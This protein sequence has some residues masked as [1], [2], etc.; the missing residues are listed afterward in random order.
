MT[1]I[2]QEGHDILEPLFT[3]ENINQEYINE[4]LAFTEQYIFTNEPT[5]DEAKKWLHEK[6]AKACDK[7]D[8]DILSSIL[9]D[10][11][12]AIQQATKE[13]YEEL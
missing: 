6:I 13:D 2:N 3:G 12:G 5:V 9:E 10:N 11:C 8:A 4:H 7:E 1:L